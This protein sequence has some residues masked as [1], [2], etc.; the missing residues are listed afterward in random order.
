MTL[1]FRAGSALVDDALSE[2]EALGD[3]RPHVCP[4]RGV[5]RDEALVEMRE[6][7]VLYITSNFELSNQ[8]SLRTATGTRSGACGSGGQGDLVARVE[9]RA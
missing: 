6:S 4:P 9:A 5:D 2:E 7:N 3:P 8:K 1:H